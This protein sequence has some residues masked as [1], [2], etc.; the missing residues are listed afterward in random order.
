MM[1]YTKT[2]VRLRNV[3]SHPLHAFFYQGFLLKFEVLYL[4]QWHSI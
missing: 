4:L 3:A 2:Y 1:F